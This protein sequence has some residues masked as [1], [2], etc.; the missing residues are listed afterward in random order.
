M[1]LLSLTS[2]ASLTE[3]AGAVLLATDYVGVSFWLVSAALL[4]ATAFFFLE[5]SNVTNKW[6]TSLTLSGL[7][8]GIAFWHY[9]YMREV[10][11]TTGQS[12]T[13]YRY[14]DWFLTVPILMA[15]FYFI[16]RAA[17]SVQ[18]S[19]FYKLFI[20]SILMLLFGFLG[21]TALM[22]V[23]PAFALAMLFWIYM[24][25]ELRMGEGAKSKNTITNVN[26][27]SAYDTMM[28]IVV[29]GW[30]VYPVGYYL[31]YL[32]GGANSNTLN[33]VYNLADFLNKI[34]F[35]VIIWNAAINDSK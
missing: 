34:V 27:K 9:L 14:I 6:K 24:I 16:L 32:G 15:E 33:L 20:G 10:W 13:V 3:M 28:W 18:V 31:G 25:Y 7:V 35:G 5:R 22:P 26:V 8:T 30:A 1:T 17:G 19:M 29:I 21:E 12:A 23:V 2:L 11:V 4:A